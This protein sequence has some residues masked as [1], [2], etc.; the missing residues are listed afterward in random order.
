M[1]PRGSEEPS[2]ADQVEQLL[3]QA[4][5]CTV[6]ALDAA[7]TALRDGD[8]AVRRRARAQMSVALKELRMY[9]T[10]MTQV[11]RQVSMDARQ[12]RV[13]INQRGR[14]AS[15]LVGRGTFGNAFRGSLE[16]GRQRKRLDLRQQ[17]GGFRTLVEDLRMELERMMIEVEKARADLEG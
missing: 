15:M 13:D 10:Q 6:D 8:A 4:E 12:A 9:K 16:R 11:Q 2:P 14:K 5:Q 3:R 17:E 1:S 7:R